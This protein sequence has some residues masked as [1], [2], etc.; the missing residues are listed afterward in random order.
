VITT[1]W[2]FGGEPAEKVQVSPDGA[3]PDLHERV[4]AS[5]EF[6]RLRRRLRWFV[7]PA[8]VLALLWYLAFV[9]LVSYYR[10]LMDR[11]LVGAVNVGL[12]LGLAQFVTTF[13]LTAAYVR[14]A[15]RKL[16]PLAAGIRE[17]VESAVPAQQTGDAR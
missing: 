16:D 4:Q 15:R 7:F 14:Y 13:A 3:A 5:A 6:V 12:A 17:R 1:G 9:L 2:E 11:P 10:D 8:T